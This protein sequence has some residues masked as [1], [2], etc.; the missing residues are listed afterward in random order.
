MIKILF[1]DWLL[2]IVALGDLDAFFP[3]ATREYAPIVLEVWKDPAIQ[4]TYKRNNELQFLPDVAS[5]FLDRVVEISSNEYEPTE[6][7]IL[8]AEGINQW[9]GLSLLEFS[10]DDQYPFPDSYVGKPDDPSMQTK[11]HLIH[12]SSKGLNGGLRCL[13]MLEGRAIVFCIS[14]TDY[15]QMWVQSSGELC[16][17]MIA[18]RN[19]FKDVI[20]YPSFEG[21]PCVLLLNKYD[22]FEV[23][24]NRVPLTV[25]DWF[26]DFSPVKPH[27][28]H[29]SLASHAYYYIA[30][31]FK[32]LYS[33]ISDRK[34][35]V[36][37]TKALERKTVDNAFRYIREIGRA[38]V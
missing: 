16:N 21:T 1:A 34:L 36:F 31:K 14:L 5:Y 32:D 18:S 38:H 30:L 8:Y 17:K 19:L 20:S 3:A 29:Q 24:I 6:L 10:L 7:D 37:Q 2:E 33:S 25:C 26:T 23:K 12:I 35:F 4:A 13:E 11:Y 27:H 28:T 22:A 15:D 9:N